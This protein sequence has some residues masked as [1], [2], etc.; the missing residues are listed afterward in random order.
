MLRVILRIT[1]IM[2]ISDDDSVVVQL[3]LVDGLGEMLE[4]LW[5]FKDISSAVSICTYLLV[6]EPK[7]REYSPIQFN[8]YN[9][10]IIMITIE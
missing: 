7:P 5:C 9:I 8:F 10:I 1:I 3:T 2:I 6:E 4:P